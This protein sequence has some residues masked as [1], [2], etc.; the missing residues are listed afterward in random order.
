MARKKIETKKQILKK[1]LPYCP[2][3]DCCWDYKKEKIQAKFCPD[4]G[5]RLAQPSI[6]PICKQPAGASN[7]FCPSCGVGIV[8]R[9]NAE[10]D[11]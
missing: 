3:C 4:C 11:N 5:M 10:K 7:R 8:R 2:G 1:M 9:E 6:C